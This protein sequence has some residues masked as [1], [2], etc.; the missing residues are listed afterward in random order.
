MLIRSYRDLEVY[1]IAYQLALEVHKITLDF[2][3]HEFY[4][5]GSQMRRASKSIALNI[6][7]GYGRRKSAE[8]FK[9]FLTMA[10]SSCDELRVQ[11]NF[12]R[13]LEYVQTEDYNKYNSKYDVLG[14]KINKLIQNWEK[15]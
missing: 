4:E 11:I 2:P 6:V 15:F 5:L 13:D 9:R 7:E 10:I 12:C 14:K 3:K 1:Q 8:E